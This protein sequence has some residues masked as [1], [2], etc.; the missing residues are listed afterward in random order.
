MQATLPSEEQVK[1]HRAHVVAGQ[2]F[3]DSEDSE[4]HAEDGESLRNQEEQEKTL[5][6]LSSLELSSSLN[7]NLEEVEV[8][9]PGSL[10]HVV[11]DVYLQSLKT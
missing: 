3:I 1:D 5:G 11:L 9:K 7:K 10:L 6:E 4:G 8:Q 2:I